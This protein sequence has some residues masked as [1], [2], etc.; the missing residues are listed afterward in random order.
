MA[1]EFESLN[2]NSIDVAQK[3]RYIA[4]EDFHLLLNMTQTQKLLYIAYGIEIARANIRLTDEHP[5][6]WPFGP[7]FP[8]VHSKVDF[9]TTPPNPDG[10]PDEIVS[11]L[12]DVVKAFGRTSATKLS[13]WSH[14]KDSPWDK[15]PKDKW[16]RSLSD[17]DIREYFSRLKY[18]KTNE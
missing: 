15:T 4:Q 14:S 1:E 2:L 3:I 9:S 18:I 5:Q 13:E 10:I 11:L 12:R 17:S 8:R 7:V 16:G 6:A